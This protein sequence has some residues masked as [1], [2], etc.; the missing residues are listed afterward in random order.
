[1]GHDPPLTD[2]L[3]DRRRER[4]HEIQTAGDPAHAPIEAAR[5]R[6]ERQALLV[7]QRVQQPALLEHAVGRVR[8]Q[9]LSQDEGIGF[10]EIPED[11][12]D[13]IAV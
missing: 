13:A 1:M 3:L 5:E 4:P 12:R 8:L 9:E 6:V 2:V 7:M 10:R 11:G